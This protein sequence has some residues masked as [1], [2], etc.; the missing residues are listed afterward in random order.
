MT[1][2]PHA[3]PA[4]TCGFHVAIHTSTRAS[5]TVDSTHE[6]AAGTPSPGQRAL[7]I[8]SATLMENVSGTT[9]GSSPCRHHRIG[10]KWYPRLK[11]TSAMANASQAF[12]DQVM[13]RWWRAPQ[14]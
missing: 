3:T 8:E 5:A 12:V 1:V 4:P 11:P 6:T 10:S 9:V 7:A 14:S 13:A 2:S